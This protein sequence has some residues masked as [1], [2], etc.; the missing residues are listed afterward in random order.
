[1]RKY[2]EGKPDIFL[3]IHSAEH[4]QQ[5][6]ADWHMQVDEDMANGEF[7]GA[8]THSSYRANA[9]AVARYK[10]GLQD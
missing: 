9:A 1:M 8:T 3:G 2:Y 7:D 6:A 5:L 10:M 4:Y